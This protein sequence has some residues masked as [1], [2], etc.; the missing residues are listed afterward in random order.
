MFIVRDSKGDIQAIC[1]RLEDAKVWM[2]ASKL[3]NET[4]NIE[5]VNIGQRE[6]KTKTRATAT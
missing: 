4:Y 1:T 3:D 5:E 2:T 6:T